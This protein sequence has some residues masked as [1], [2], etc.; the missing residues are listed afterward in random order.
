MMQFNWEVWND[1][2]LL[3][4]YVAEHYGSVLC[5]GGPDDQRHWATKF[6]QRLA[7]ISKLSIDQVVADVRADYRTMAHDG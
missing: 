1:A 2:G 5:N 3:R 4:E 6:C 7:R